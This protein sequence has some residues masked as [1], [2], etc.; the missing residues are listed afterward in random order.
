MSA[1]YEDKVRALRRR[2]QKLESAVVAFSGGVDS[3][4]LVALAFE[5]LGSRM[6]AA[7]ALSPSTPERDRASSAQI[8]ARIG[9]PHRFVETGEFENPAFTSNPEERCYF[10]KRH[11][12][13]RMTGLADELGFAF[14]V[15]GTNASDLGG[16][17]PG[18]RASRENGR[19][20]TP[21]VDEGFTKEE[22]RR[23]ATELGLESAQK[24]ASACLASRVPTGVTLT[25]ELMQRID[26]AEEAVRRLVP[27]Q[28]RVR[29]HGE[30]A[31]IELGENTLL[32]AVENRCEIVSKL[33]ELGWKFVSLDLCG[34][35]TGGA[36]G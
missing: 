27:G 19:V 32:A 26:A 36:Q 9:A 30:L 24:P 13:E 8:C 29:H 15:E 1:S 4:V 6:A 33:R 14:V 23:L 7:T 18:Y 22:V 35:R 28:V 16:H 25:P 20:A 34:Y 21:L 3:S 17:R 11:L 2:L 10:C 12:Y 5:E 31:R